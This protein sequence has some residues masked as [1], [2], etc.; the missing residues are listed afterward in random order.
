MFLA[1]FIDEQVQVFLDLF[2]DRV[3]R[4][5]W[6]ALSLL[7]AHRVHSPQVVHVNLG[8]YLVW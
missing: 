6:L 5:V 7:R 3:D 8:Q 4:V 2:Q 1:G